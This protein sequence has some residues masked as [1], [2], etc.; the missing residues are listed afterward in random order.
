MGFFLKSAEI[1]VN[2]F[3]QKIEKLIEFYI[4]KILQ[5]FS[6]FLVKKWIFSP[7]TKKKTFWALEYVGTDSKEYENK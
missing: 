2:F 3:A 5:K 7:K 4:T 1:F 6:S